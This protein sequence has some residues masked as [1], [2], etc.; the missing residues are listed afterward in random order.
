MGWA[1][2]AVASAA[3]CP[4]YAQAVVL[5]D[6]GESGPTEASGLAASRDRPGVLYTH[7]DGGEPVLYALDEAGVLVESHGVEGAE[8]VDWEDLATGPCPDGGNC[9]YIGDIGD[10]DGE[11]TW[12]DIYVAAEPATGESVVVQESWR[13]QWPGG[14]VDAETLLVH[15][16]TGEVSL[17]SKDPSG[18]SLVG[19]LPA[20]PGAMIATLEIVATLLLQGN[21]EGERL[22]AGGAWDADGERLAIRARER[23]YEW[24]TDPCDPD[25]HWEDTPEAWKTPASPRAEGVDYGSNGGLF[26]VAEGSPALVAWEACPDLEASTGSCPEEEEEACG[27]T[28]SGAGAWVLLPL[29]GV[30]LRRREAGLGE[31]E[32]GR[33]RQGQDT[34]VR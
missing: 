13:A 9:L 26:Y 17:V 18:L 16:V 20:D 12:V 32:P 29:F 33:E 24:Q 27:C 5:G 28:R 7:D 25:G 23:L 34:S 31:E 11:R 21:D 3:T 15:P 1:W 22:A 19:R 2:F 6:L 8:V 30:S 10:N 4:D 14:P